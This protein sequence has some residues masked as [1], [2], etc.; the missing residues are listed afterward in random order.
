MALTLYWVS[1]LKDFYVNIAVLFSFSFFFLPPPRDYIG[2]LERV[3]FL[4]FS[5]TH[6]KHI[7]IFIASHFI[8]ETE[9]QIKSLKLLYLF[10]L[11]LFW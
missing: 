10:A 5:S 9:L 1:Q 8:N 7:L 4:N 3:F 2:F 6:L 11:D